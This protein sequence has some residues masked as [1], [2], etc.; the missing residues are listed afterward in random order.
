MN[1]TEVKQARNN[2]NVEYINPVTLEDKKQVYSLAHFMRI[3][4]SED[5][6]LV[7]KI[8]RYKKDKIFG[9]FSKLG[10]P[11]IE[12]PKSELTLSSIEL[13]NLVKYI[14]ENYYPLQNNETKYLAFDDETMYALIKENPENIFKL[15]E[16]AL[17]NDIDLSDINKLIEISDRKR[18]IEEFKE[19]YKNNVEEKVWQKW[20]EK[21]N[22]VFGS[23]FVRISDDRR[24]DVKNIS[25]FIVENI[26]GFV[27]VIEIKRVS[28]STNF[29]DN[30][31]DHNNIV[32]SHELTK[33]ITQLANYLSTLEKKSNDL[34]TTKRI[35]RILKPRGILIFGSSRK[36]ATEQ[37]EAFRLL[38][39]SLVNITIYTYDMVYKRATKMNEYLSNENNE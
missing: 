24:I 37:W 4:T 1:L 35:G 34:D 6:K 8:G 31:T 20:F 15:V 5:K 26:D 25:D 16:I 29:F 33:A 39:S 10:N 27:D 12:N 18:A 38:N 30:S 3:K 7:L 21:N 11:L 22:W 9:I 2:D 17:T 19:N 23:D 28:D 14:S 13:E 32:P 36:W